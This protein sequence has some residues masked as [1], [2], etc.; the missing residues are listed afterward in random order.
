MTQFV[1]NQ[2]NGHTPHTKLDLVGR[3]A[4]F[5]SYFWYHFTL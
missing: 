2:K 3:L 5:G 1:K 4:A